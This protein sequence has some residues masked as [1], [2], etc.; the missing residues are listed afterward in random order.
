LFFTEVTAPAWR[1]ALCESPRLRESNINS[2]AKQKKKSSI[3]AA[4]QED[5]TQ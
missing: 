3:N 5:G 1:A 2:N 4:R